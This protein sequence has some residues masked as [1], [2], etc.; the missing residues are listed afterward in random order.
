MINMFNN[1]GYRLDYDKKINLYYVVTPENESK[2]YDNP[3]MAWS[4]YINQLDAAVR[5]SIGKMLESAGLNRYTGGYIDGA[6]D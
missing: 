2:C 5:R 3:L 1:R 4:D 6:S